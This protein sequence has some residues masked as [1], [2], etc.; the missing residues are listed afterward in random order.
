MNDRDNRAW[1]FHKAY[2]NAWPCWGPTAAD[3]AA[4]DQIS[5]DIAEAEKTKGKP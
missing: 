3:F 2:C 1:A 5:A 4:V